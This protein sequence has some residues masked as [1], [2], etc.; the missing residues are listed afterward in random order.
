MRVWIEIISS[1]D[2]GSALSVTL[3]VRVWIEIDVSEG[4]QYTLTSPST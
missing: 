1:M 4:A 2:L 3:H